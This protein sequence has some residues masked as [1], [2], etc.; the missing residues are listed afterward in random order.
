MLSM[1][2]VFGTCSIMTKQTNEYRIL[3]TELNFFLQGTVCP[4]IQIYRDK[5][6]V[7][8]NYSTNMNAHSTEAKRKYFDRFCKSGL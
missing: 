2:K 8:L 6:A 3:H 7:F 1:H 5:K 4:K